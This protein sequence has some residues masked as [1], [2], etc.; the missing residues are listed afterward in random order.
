[1]TEATRL[2][3]LFARVESA[4]FFVKHFKEDRDRALAERDKALAELAE[5]KSSRV[6]NKGCWPL[7]VLQAEAGATMKERERCIRLLNGEAICLSVLDTPY[8][9]RHVTEAELREAL[10]PK[11]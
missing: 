6:T 8:E 10:E 1:M 7:V 9:Y 11:P 3:D 5:L 4:E 2:L